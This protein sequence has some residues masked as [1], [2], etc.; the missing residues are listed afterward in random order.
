MKKIKQR[1]S[2]KRAGA[3]EKHKT[4]AVEGVSGKRTGKS[5]RKAARRERLEVKEKQTG[6]DVDGGTRKKKGAAKQT[7]KLKDSIADAPVPMQS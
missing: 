5:Q 1:V 3:R 7:K 6:M 4:I 2:K